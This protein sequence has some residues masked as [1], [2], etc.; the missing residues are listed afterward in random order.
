MAHGGIIAPRTIRVGVIKS[1]FVLPLVSHYATF[2]LMR[3]LIQIIEDWETKAGVSASTIGKVRAGG[4]AGPKT[5]YKI[6][7]ALGG[8]PEEAKA[9][10]D[11]VSAD[12]AKETA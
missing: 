2:C 3:R 4:K 5:A 1:Y 12:D 10:A 8:D 6:V 11:E 9:A 7:M